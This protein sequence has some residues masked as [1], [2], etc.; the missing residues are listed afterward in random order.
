MSRRRHTSSHGKQRCPAGILHHFRLMNDSKL[1]P[2]TLRDARC[3]LMVM[4]G[5]RW[6]GRF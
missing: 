4:A 5:S 1:A 3:R 2:T 6:T